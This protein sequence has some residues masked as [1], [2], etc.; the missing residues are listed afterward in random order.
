MSQSLSASA[1]AVANPITI[2]VGFA[3]PASSGN[4]QV[5][6]GVSGQ[7]VFQRSSGTAIIY[8]T[9]PLTSPVIGARFTLSSAFADITGTKGCCLL[10][11]AFNGYSY[12]HQDGNP[13][14]LQIRLI[15]GGVLQAGVLYSVAATTGV[16]DDVF[17][18]QATGNSF[19]IYQNGV[20][21]NTGGTAFVDTTYTGLQYGGSMVES[22]T[23]RILSFETF[24]IG[25]S[26]VSLTDPLVM[27][28]PLTLVTSGFSNITSIAGAGLSATGLS[29]SSGTTTGT[30]PAISESIAPTV[31]LPA[32]GATITVS[33]GS[34][35][36]T[37]VR[38][39]PLA[40]GWA[41]VEFGVLIDEPDYLLSEIPIVDG[42]Y[43]YYETNQ[44]VVGDVIIY[45]DGGV[46][47]DNPG[48]F[49][50]YLHKLGTGEPLV[51]YDVTSGGGGESSG[52]L[53]VAGISNS[54]LSNSGLSVTGL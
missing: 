41:S 22:G 9:T 23:G 6:T 14:T 52:G 3:K 35:P 12:S 25:G 8:G 43:A 26:V 18:I 21:K 1:F 11:S 45:P 33:D 36:T 29:Y 46:Y 40:T 19:E 27:G 48:T 16:N 7:K 50:L 39:I 28:S 38:D 13:G 53:S 47:T 54:G 17:E 32:T 34:N 31:A 42:Y 24:E 20:L 37:I 15:I 2:P 44:P 49:S 30:W 5:L 4:T 10:N 51:R